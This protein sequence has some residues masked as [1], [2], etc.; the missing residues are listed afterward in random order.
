ML[1]PAPPLTSLSFR[2]ATFRWAPPGATTGRTSARHLL[3]TI[4]PLT[5]QDKA[6]FAA[7]LFPDSLP[8]R[9]ARITPK[10]VDKPNQR[11]ISL[12]YRIYSAFQNGVGTEALRRANGEQK[13]SQKED[14]E[15]P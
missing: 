11:S 5:H 13:Q 2:A 3:S 8:D 1:S 7:Q 15:N 9:V 10:Q 6:D 4:N 14:K 12:F